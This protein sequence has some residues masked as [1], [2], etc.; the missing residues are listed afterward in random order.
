MKKNSYIHN[1]GVAAVNNGYAVARLKP[2]SKMPIGEKWPDN[3][4]TV[5]MCLKAP[6]SQGVGV[7]CGRGANPVM[8][9]DVDCE[10][11]AVSS[12]FLGYLLQKYSW[13]N[14]AI[15]RV[16]KAPKFLLVVRADK[17]GYGY[18]SS[19]AY[20]LEGRK[21]RLEILGRNRQFVAYNV[22]PDTGLPYTYESMDAVYDALMGRGVRTPANT[23]VKDLPVVTPEIISDVID[24]FEATCLECGGVPSANGS[25]AGHFLV[26]E[27]ADVFDSIQPKN[28]IGLTI[29][30]LRSLVMP[31]APVSGEY[32]SWLEMLARLHHETQGS[33]EGL[34]LAIEFSEAAPNYSGADEVKKKWASFKN[35]GNVLTMWPIAKK[36]NVEKALMAELS[37]Q[38][39]V[40]RLIHKLGDR[41]VCLR[42]NSQWML[43]SDETHQWYDGV[44]AEFELNRQIELV[45]DKDL[46]EEA[47]KEPDEERKAEIL[48]FRKA[49]VYNIGATYM[50][51]QQALR[52]AP[53]RIV[54]RSD[55]DSDLKYFGL[56][57]G[58]EH[59]VLDRDTGV[60]EVCCA[61]HRVTK[62]PKWDFNPE[63]TCP[64]TLK[65]FH[66]WIGDE[67][68]VK[69]FLTV[70]SRA[71]F[72]DNSDNR[73][74]VLLGSGA[75]GKSTCL[76]VISHLFGSY[77]AVLSETAFVK[78]SDKD[79]SSASPE[80]MP[81]IGARVAVCS[82]VSQQA[83]LKE[84]T[85]KRFTGGDACACRTLYDRTMTVFTPHALPIIGSN[86]R[87][88][89]RGTDNGIWRRMFVI[90][91]NRRFGNKSRGFLREL[92]GEVPGLFNYLVKLYRDTKDESLETPKVMQDA[93]SEYRDDMDFVKS[94]IDTR[95][96]VEEGSRIST[97]DL[98]VQFKSYMEQEGY[99][100]GLTKRGFTERVKKL[101]KEGAL[102]KSNGSTYFKGYR[103]RSQAEVENIFED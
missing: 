33:D 45:V 56:K 93:V 7:I 99:R 100:W 70:L 25:D 92:L 72:G 21:C 63:A 16:G 55:F 96:A 74:F 101:L 34:E 38:G 37:D 86:Y 81:L 80:L 48:K 20:F 57:I 14:D 89:I 64:K 46:L 67:A 13:V 9:I 82:E 68:T 59:Y 58:G 41:L 91:F 42:E 28:P 8:G 60:I 2:N 47:E 66:E 35:S 69:F 88:N 62:F 103:L 51:V 18:A 83:V 79:G 87:P 5:D 30:E 76:N 27:E 11:E 24:L 29:D 61:E 39:L 44:A 12:K 85:V 3:P 102:C 17:A 97:L 50:R 10:N 73:F 15:K 65:A 75:N 95:V 32:Q 78:F 36:G 49:R 52:N 1:E 43:F 94:F 54:S 26:R 98:Y 22:H 84:S 31:Y 53:S 4:Q 6:A 71:L 90:E 77:S 40:L 19:Q 23:H